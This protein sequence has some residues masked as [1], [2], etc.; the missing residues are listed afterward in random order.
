VSK[1]CSMVEGSRSAQGF[2]EIEAEAAVAFA[3]GFVVTTRSGGD[4]VREA[5]SFGGRPGHRRG[6]RFV[7]VV[8]MYRSLPSRRLRVV[9]GAVLG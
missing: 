9:A 2:H 1:S 5:G 6:R 7:T 4:F 8:C 3:L